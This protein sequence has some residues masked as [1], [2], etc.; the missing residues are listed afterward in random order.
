MLH[1]TVEPTKD[2]KKN[3][4]KKMFIKEAIGSIKTSGTISPSSKYLIND[5]L[6]DIDF[7]KANTIVE[8][9]AGD[10][11]FTKEL[12]NRMHDSAKLYSFEINSKFYDY[13]SNQFQDFGN[14]QIINQSALEFDDVLAQD[15]IDQV[16]YFVS[17]L[18]LTL[19][20]PADVEILLNKV[21]KHLSKDGLFIQYQYSLDKYKQLKT[22]FDKVNL[23]LT[24]RNLPPAFIY[25]CAAA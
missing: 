13:C 16:D 20:K 4:N 24:V 12:A 22:T 1:L 23:G 6:K 19:L 14:V 18:P 8:F 15:N 25:K 5:C 11:C 9:G 17:S 3:K 21:T 10:G 7:T 2:M